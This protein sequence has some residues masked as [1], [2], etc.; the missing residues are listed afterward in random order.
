MKTNKR[1]R[2]IACKMFAEHLEDRRLLAADGLRLPMVLKNAHIASFFV[3]VM[4]LS[5]AHPTLGSTI[6]VL[7][8]NIHPSEGQDS[9]FDLDRIADVINSATPD[10]VA[11]QELDQ[12]NARSGFDVFQLDRL[13]QLTGLQG[14]F[15]KT[16]SYRGGEYGIG[17]LVNPTITITDTVKHTLPN[18]AVGEPRALI[19]MDLSID[20]AIS[21]VPFK[22][23]AT[24]FDHSSGANRRAQA[25]FVNDRVTASAVPALLAGDLNAQPGW[26]VMRTIFE[27]WTNTSNLGSQIDYVLYRD[28]NQFA[29]VEEGQ[30]IIN[31]TTA[32]AFRSLSATH[33]C[34][35][36]T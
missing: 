28:A 8:Y 26:G 34:Q 31:P 12:G 14:Y 9:V 18:P 17:V 27:E 35:D 11:L 4:S 30:F 19:E 5:S 33:R 23:F 7:T 10:I 24:H 1:S 32:I 36:R 25:A 29:V 13:S 20:Y 21:T 3:I 15:A 2:H 6:R 22:L 16:I